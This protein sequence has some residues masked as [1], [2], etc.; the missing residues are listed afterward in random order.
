MAE[1]SGWVISTQRIPPPQV[2]TVKN[3]NELIKTKVNVTCSHTMI[4]QK[5][6]CK[7]VIKTV[8]AK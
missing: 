3:V 6:I 7:V 2:T 1:V 5:I 8:Q 4:A